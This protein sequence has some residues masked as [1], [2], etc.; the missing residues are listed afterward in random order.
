KKGFKIKYKHISN[1]A[2]T[3]LWKK[4]H[5]NLVRTGISNY[6]LWP[7]QEVFKMIDLKPVMT[8]KTIVSQ[9]RTINEGE[10]IGYGCTHKT[11]RKTKTAVLPIGYYDGYDRGLSNKGYV[12]IHGKRA[13]ILGRICMNVIMVDI[14]DIPNVKLEDEAVLLG[15]QKN[16]EI[17]AEEMASWAVTINYEI[18]TRINEKIPRILKS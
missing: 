2:A 14:T 15:K 16:D 3:M 4:A 8:W 9:V 6:G 1:S 17:T 11:T 12:L 18:T 10:F 7:S 5:F 13:K